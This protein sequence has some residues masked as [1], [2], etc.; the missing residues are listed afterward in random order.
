MYTRDKKHV[1]KFKSKTL[2]KYQLKPLISQKICMVTS[3]FQAYL[4]DRTFFHLFLN[5]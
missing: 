3:S 2:I 1:F 4:K 5:S